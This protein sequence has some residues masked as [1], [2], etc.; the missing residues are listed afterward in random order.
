MNI[1]DL[2]EKEGLLDDYHRMSDKNLIYAE[3]FLKVSRHDDVLP[4]TVI[5]GSINRLHLIKNKMK[6]NDSFI[7]NAVCVDIKQLLTWLEEQRKTYGS[8]E[9][10]GLD[11][12]AEEKNTD[13][14]VDETTDE[15]INENELEDTFEEEDIDIFTGEEQQTESQESAPNIEEWNKDPHN[16]EKFKFEYLAEPVRVS[17]IAHDFSFNNHSPKELAYAFIKRYTTG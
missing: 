1:Y 13:I 16:H 11:D 3:E 10:I 7:H 14:A 8:S 4:N 12:E 6:N 5:F 2:F 17:A 15:I 9:I